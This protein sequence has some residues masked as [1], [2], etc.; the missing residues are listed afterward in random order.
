MRVV[1]NAY[2]TIGNKTGIGHYTEELLRCLRDRLAPE[3]LFA[4]PHGLL[5]GLHVAWQRASAATPS[6]SAQRRLWS[7]G[8]LRLAAIAFLKPFGRAIRTTYA[9]SILRQGK[10]DLYHEP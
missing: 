5:R 2:S 8:D 6:D 1:L 4:F 7:P 9:R 3:E 10:F